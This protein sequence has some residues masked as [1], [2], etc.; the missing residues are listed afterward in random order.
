VLTVTGTLEQLLR[1]VPTP[2]EAGSFVRAVVTDA[3]VVLDA[4]QRLAAVYP[5]IVEIILAPPQ[6]DGADSAGA[7]GRGTQAP[8]QIAERFWVESVGAEPSDDERLLL[9]SALADAEAKVG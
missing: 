6:L 2:V 7:L 9:H 3:G 5:S 1:H 4:K 8:A